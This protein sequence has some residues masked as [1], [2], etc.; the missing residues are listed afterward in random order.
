MTEDGPILPT[1]KSTREP[2]NSLDTKV[3]PQS[4]KI[5]LKRQVNT[6]LKDRS[7]CQKQDVG[8][9][10]HSGQNHLLASSGK[11]HQAVPGSDRWGGHTSRT[12]DI[13]M[14]SLGHS[15]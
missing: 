1:L 4:L 3:V 2:Q 7:L 10:R 11:R 14:A 15:C 5:A 13:I 9:V 6:Q 8:S 12:K